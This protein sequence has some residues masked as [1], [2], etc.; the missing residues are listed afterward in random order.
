M[1]AAI[2][3]GGIMGGTGILLESSLEGERQ[4]LLKYF[5]LFLVREIH[6]S[7]GNWL[8]LS[9]GGMIATGLVMWAYPLWMRRQHAFSQPKT[10]K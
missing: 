5:N 6:A 2:A 1:W 8:I 3:F 9:L 4:W 7:F 10:E